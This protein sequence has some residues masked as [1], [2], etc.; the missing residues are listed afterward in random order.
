MVIGECYEFNLHSVCVYDM[1]L[2]FAQCFVH[3]STVFTLVLLVNVNGQQFVQC[4]FT[5]PVRIGFGAA[6]DEFMFGF[7]VLPQ[8][9]ADIIAKCAFSVVQHTCN[10][11]WFL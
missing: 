7:Y 1:A 4:L 2:D 8:I 11:Q 9:V 10:G 3:I 5:E 6:K